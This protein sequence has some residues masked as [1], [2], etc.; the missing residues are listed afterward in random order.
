MH[1]AVPWQH[2]ASPPCGGTGTKVLGAAK[3]LTSCCPLSSS[4]S[5]HQPPPSGSW[6]KPPTFFLG[7]AQASPSPVLCGS[8]P[9]G[10]LGGSVG[11]HP[12][13]ATNVCNLGGSAGKAPGPLQSRIQARVR[14]RWDCLHCSWSEPSW[15]ARG[16][17][18]HYAGFRPFW[19]TPGHTA[20]PFSCTA[21][22][23]PAPEGPSR[24]SWEAFQSVLG[25]SHALHVSTLLVPPFPVLCQ[26]SPEK[27][28]L[29]QSNVTSALLFLGPN[30]G[31][32]PSTL[33]SILKRFFPTNCF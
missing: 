7:R 29:S 10:H 15:P 6:W 16:Q 17:V 26:L 28:K 11:S 21:A 32:S 33:S 2:Q 27:N 8:V 14:L 1:L 30:L 23:R 25:A 22:P 12:S 18:R 9:V 13:Q 3:G 20:S 24:V 5:G 4:P 31:V 19:E